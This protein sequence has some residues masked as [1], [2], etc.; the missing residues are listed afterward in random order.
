MVV[1]FQRAR[2]PE[3]KE[4]RR[5]HLLATAR[6]MLESGVDLRE[7]SLNEIA[8]RARMAKS[9]VYRYFETREAVLLALL[10]EE[11]SAWYEQMTRTY[12]RPSRGQ[13]ALDAIV[14]HLARTL[15]AR[16]LLCALTTAA[17]LVLERNLG[18]GA[19][20]DFKTRMVQTFREMGRF[21]SSVAPDLTAEQ[22]AGLVHDATAIIAG[23]YP[24]GFPAEHAARIVAEPAFKLVRR[25]F[26]RDMERF[27]LALAHDRQ[28]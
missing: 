16:P 15:A 2:Q 17:P 22:F 21:L 25:D 12:R 1:D 27:F 18:E 24:Q 19:I 10:W 9:N 3:Q 26:A 4:E 7:L 14:R 20:R 28:K 23:L 11:W 5:A 6:D 8:R 13:P